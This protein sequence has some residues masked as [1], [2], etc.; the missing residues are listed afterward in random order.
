[1]AWPTKIFLSVN[2]WPL[3]HRSRGLRVHVTVPGLG[4][5]S[6]SGVFSQLFLF[7]LPFFLSD[8]VDEGT[9]WRSRGRS[10]S[11]AV[12]AVRGRQLPFPVPVLSAPLRPKRSLKRPSCF[13]FS[14]AF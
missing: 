14:K 11:Q 6:I 1:M 4:K 7:L 2:V 10:L 9:F 12:S 8:L 5:M 13:V 3:R